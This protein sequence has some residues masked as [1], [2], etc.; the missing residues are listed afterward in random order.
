[1]KFFQK[2]IL[3]FLFSSFSGTS[4]QATHIVGGELNYRC[5]TGNLYEISLTVFRDCQNGVPPFDAQAAVGIFDSSNI[6]VTQLLIPFMGDDTLNPTL[7]DSCL[8]IPPDVCVHRTTYIDTIFLPF[9]AGGYQL[10]YQRCCRNNTILNIQNPSQTGATYYTQVSELALM[11]CNSNPVFNAWPPIYI[12]TGEPILFN[13]SATD[14]D[15]D[16]LIYEL[17]APFEG[18]VVTNSMPQP[19]NPPPYDSIIWQF[20][21]ST[22]NMMGGI[23]LLK[24]NS[25]TGLLTG[26][27]TQVGQYVVGI[28]VKEYRN[29]I[30]ISTTKRDFQYNV[31]VCG[32]IHNAAFFT[33]SVVCD[34]NLVVR[35]N[36]QSTTVSTY[37]WD[38][39]DLMT[40]AD[41]SNSTS[42]AYAYSD[43]GQY[44]VTLIA[45]ANEACADTFTKILNV[46]DAT[47]IADF[48]VVY[49]PCIDS[50]EIQLVDQSTN[51][52]S[53]I[54]S[55]QW[56]FWDGSVGSV[57]NPVDT[58]YGQENYQIILIVGSE[59]GCYDLKADS[60][61][62]YPVNI[63]TQASRQICRGGEMFLDVFNLDS[64]DNLSYQWFPDNEIV[65]G[66][67]TNNPIVAP[68]QTTDFWVA[69]TN[70]YNCTTIDTVTVPISN[71]F[72]MLNIQSSSDSTFPGEPIQLTAT[73]DGNYLYDWLVDSSLSTN[74]IHNPVATPYVPTVYYLI[75]EDEN[76]CKNIDTISILIRQFECELPYIFIPNAFT[77]NNDGNNDEFFVRANSIAEVYLAVY[78]RWGQKVFE[79]NNLNQGWDGTFNGMPLEPDVF[80]YYLEIECFNGFK[81]FKKGNVALIR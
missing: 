74:G 46:H 31:G 79:T 55:W 66:Q 38:F 65:F 10:V 27:P 78:N 54:S 48:S 40:S 67:N 80:G 20:P 24:I 8:V 37:F 49:D 81:Q 17:C 63:S 18:A 35:F 57:Q 77:P 53:P 23:D 51:P 44:V 29:G 45:G 7:F 22:S 5:L 58:I 16:S 1:M 69:A 41:T 52:N 4:I 6:L 43:T 39:G 28:C 26:T 68:I 12:C 15:G 3:L 2:I 60:I 21:F 25:Q 62:S 64:A 56:I 30:L 19:P 36:N 32:A 70:Q 9:V 47:I 33:P 59:N 42:P 14:Y 76:G 61:K 72:P 34:S 11:T 73:F 75:V 13:H 50:T 71:I